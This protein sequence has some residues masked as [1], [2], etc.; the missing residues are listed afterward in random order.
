MDTAVRFLIE[1]PV[2]LGVFAAVLFSAVRLSFVPA[3]RKRCEW[4]LAASALALP[5]A[6]SCDA[7]TRWMSHLTPIKLDLY[8]FQID[9][10][11]GQP[12]FLLGQFVG[13]HF[14]LEAVSNMAYSALP[15][16]ILAVLAFYLW[17][18][19]EVEALTVLRTFILNLFLAVPIYLLI[20]ACGPAYTFPAFPVL[21]AHFVARGIALGG[22]ANCVPSV[23]ASTA[24]LILCFAWRWRA[25]RAL[26]LAYLVLIV[27]ATLGSGQHYLFDLIVAVPYTALVL[28]LGKIERVWMPSH[29]KAGAEMY[30]RR[31][32]SCR[33]VYMRSHRRAG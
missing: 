17:R 26:G 7:L 16:A 3:D 28:R 9:A 5:A 33:P 4:F 19:S 10:H 25:A 8:I 14:W 24:L 6:G 18:R 13:R 20:P 32:C 22:P 21:P 30:T 27:I 23:H 31:V 29:E 12:S 15:C 2:V 1:Y 11:F